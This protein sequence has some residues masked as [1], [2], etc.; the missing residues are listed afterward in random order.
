M[1]M[2]PRMNRRQNRT[3]LPAAFLAGLLLAAIIPSGTSTVHA[4]DSSSDIPGVPLPGPVAAGRLGGGIYDVVYRIVVAP[5]NVIVASLSGATGTDFDIYL[6]DGS[7]TTVLSSVGLLKK[8]TGPTSDESISW[9]SPLGGTYYIDLNGATDV[10]GDYRLTLATVPDST[11]PSVSMLLAG[12]RG[13]TNSLTVPIALSATDDLSG[14]A[15]MA[16][17]ADG[18]SFRPWESFRATTTWTFGQ[19]DGPRN[20][21]VKVRN[22]VGLES[23]AATA[24]VAID[25]DPPAVVQFSPAP[26]A[27]VVGLRPTF[28]ISFDEAIDPL[29][30]AS[31]G[32]IVQEATGSLVSGQYAYDPVSR[33]GTFIPGFGLEPGTTYVV[34]IGDVRDVAGNRVTPVASWTFVP[35]AA[36]ILQAQ[37]ASSAIVHGASLR[38]DLTLTDA[39]APARIDVSYQWSGSAGF[40]PLTTLDVVN[41]RASLVVSPELN[42]T[43]RFRYAGAPSVAPAQLDV[44]VLV[45]RS[46][47]LV[48]R[49]PTTVARARVGVAVTVTAAISPAV[50]GLPLSF[51]LYRFDA[52]RRVWVY[53]GSRGRNADAS[54]RASLT[55]VPPS[56]G[57]YYWRATVASTPEYANNTSPVYRWSV[58]R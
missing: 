42:T 44:P 48:G 39:P 49:S 47:V 28:T 2:H 6:F 43:Y 18:L 37:K 21:W 26:G 46:V 3:R 9:P 10:E 52:A 11:P 31:F 41:G 30:W 25:T 20:L 55:W 23:A 19:G 36:P 35:F 12:G 50:A 40:Q 17:S 57:S 56:V 32:L 14:V 53:A 38:I 58:T 1:T 4:A 29:T 34:T 51:R 24:S 13:S 7:A 45:R 22:G 8:S 5:G 16:F 33:S 27:T 15:E 54:G